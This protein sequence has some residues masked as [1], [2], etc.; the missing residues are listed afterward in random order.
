[1]EQ[2]NALTIVSDIHLLFYSVHSLFLSSVVHAHTNTQVGVA[3]EEGVATCLW[4][5]TVA[6]L[7]LISC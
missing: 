2:Q 3:T 5:L 1:M 6:A 7:A 4:C